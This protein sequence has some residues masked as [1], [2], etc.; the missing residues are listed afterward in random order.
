M[1]FSFDSIFW[2]IIDRFEPCVHPH[3]S[4][5]S[6]CN[7]TIHHL[8]PLHLP[9]VHFWLT[10]P[11]NVKC[12]TRLAGISST[13]FLDR[14]STLARPELWCWK[15]VCMID[16]HSNISNIQ[17]WGIRNQPHCTL[18]LT[19][20]CDFANFLWWSSRSA[21]WLLSGWE[22]Q[23]AQWCLTWLDMSRFKHFRVAGVEKALFSTPS[24]NGLHQDMRIPPF[25]YGHQHFHQNAP[26]PR[27]SDTILYFE[28]DAVAF[29]SLTNDNTTS[30]RRTRRIARLW[31]I[32][33]Q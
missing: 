22:L 7:R 18:D 2:S 10:E 33:L 4:F 17:G 15:K 27:K 29:P 13:T 20:F 5:F 9:N 6:S 28:L 16:I 19:W 32:Q 26:S 8:I 14:R 3:V 30:V 12:G 25:C 31:T 24:F 1:C 21:F 23:S 11:S